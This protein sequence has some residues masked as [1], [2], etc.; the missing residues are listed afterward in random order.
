VGWS[1]HQKPTDTA[2]LIPHLKALK[3]SL[4]TLP[5]TIADDAGYGSEENIAFL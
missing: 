1:I 3:K 4:C 5:T 2:C